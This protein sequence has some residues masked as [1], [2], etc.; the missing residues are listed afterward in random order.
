MRLFVSSLRAA[1]EKRQPGFLPRWDGLRQCLGAACGAQNLEHV[2]EG[3]SISRLGDEDGAAH[4][5]HQER[6]PEARCGDDVAQ[7]KAEVLLDVGHAPQR[8]D[9][10][11]VDAPVE[12]VEESARGLRSSVFDL[13][14]AWH[15]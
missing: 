11:Q 10:P 14:G 9:G 15:R 2:G 6:D 12:P 8:Q 1:L 13:E 3:A 7:V 5:E 4:Q